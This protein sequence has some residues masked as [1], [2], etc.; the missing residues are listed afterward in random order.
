MKNINKF[1]FRLLTILTFCGTSATAQDLLTVEQAVAI[2]LENNYDIQISSNDLRVDQ[3]NATIGNAGILPTVSAQIVDNNS[4]QNSSQ[5]RSD[6]TTTSLDNARN[7]SL[8]YGVVLDWTVFDGFRMFARYN[9]LKELRKLGEAE[10]Q[11][12]V[13]TRVSDVITTYYDIVQQ[14]QQ[15][16]A[17]DSTMIISE[18]RVELAQN[19]FTIGKS[20]RLEVL[21]AQVDL[22]SD[23]TT[24]LRQREMYANTKILLN[25]LLARDT[26]M[27]FRVV[28][29]INV[30][31][32]MLLP[33]LETLALR[34]NPQ[35]QAQ[36]INRRIAE[37]QLKQVRAGRYPTV[38]V[39]TGYNF[40]ESESSLGFTSASSAKGLNYGF[41]ARINLFDGL[42]QSRNERVAKIAI[43]NSQLVIEQQN[44]TLLAS[45]GTAYQSYLTNITLIE[46]ER[47]NEALAR[48]NLEITREKFRIGTIPT[49]EFRT[50][51][52]NYLNASVRLS[53]AIYEAKLSE[54]TL[55]ELAGNLNLQ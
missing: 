7:N 16:A 18:Q 3:A 11:L 27:N 39:T 35:L 51:Q 31:A 24:M 52:L 21:N 22:N 44:Q 14:Q 26:K 5:T 50:A 43:E 34:Q 41:N 28:D 17:L 37:L 45:L 23:R 40:A 42:N 30:D 47:G 1:I 15:L 10:L 9:Q 4:I 13:L 19:R 36:L 54:T 2:A 20:S 53:N 8:N 25:Q 6:G 48:Q 32:T 49:I 46:L 33:D 12:T 29:Q 38:A 55:K